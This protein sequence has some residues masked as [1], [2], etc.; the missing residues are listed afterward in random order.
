M[1]DQHAALMEIYR[2]LKPGSGDKSDR[3]WPMANLSNF[4]GLHKLFFFQ[5]PGRLSEDPKN[6]PKP[7]TNLA[8][9][10]APENGWLEDK[11]LISGYFQGTKC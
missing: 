4:W 1:D 5:G 11:I 9:K 10:L 7:E 2:V 8:S 6:L 3:T